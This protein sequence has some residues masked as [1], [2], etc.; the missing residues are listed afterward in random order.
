MVRT[1]PLWGQ[2]CLSLL[3]RRWR[4]QRVQPHSSYSGAGGGSKYNPTAP[5]PALAGA[6]RTTPQLSPQR[7]Q[8]EARHA[9]PPMPCQ[10]CSRGL[11]STLSG[12]S[13]VAHEGT[14][15]G[16]APSAVSWYLH[17]G[18]SV[19]VDALVR[20][21]LGHGMITAQ[22]GRSCCCLTCFDR[23]AAWPGRPVLA[24]LDPT[25]WAAS[26]ALHGQGSTTLASSSGDTL[27]TARAANPCCGANWLHAGIQHNAPNSMHGQ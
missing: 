20:H 4:G 26:P 5:T 25:A 19:R 1:P 27:C 14:G 15:T 11:E 9:I 21:D 8:R 24:L 22:Q 12:S 2:L 3:L 17:K 10:K 16:I 7:F 23:T 6:A 13:L 18:P